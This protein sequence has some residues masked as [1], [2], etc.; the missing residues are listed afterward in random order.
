MSEDQFGIDDSKIAYH[1]DRVNQWLK[2]SGNVE[3]QLLVYPIYIEI[4]PMGGCNHRCT[5]CAVD[6]LGYIDSNILIPDILKDRLDE[7]GEKGVKSIMYAGEGEPLMSKNLA[8]IIRHT[9]EEAGI[10]VA[11]T[12]NA[13]PLTEKFA[14]A[15]LPYTTWI[16]ASIN[17]GT[18]EDYAKIHRA[19]E[20][21]FERAWKNMK[22]AAEIRDEL[23]LDHD[24]HTLGAQMVLLP[25]NAEHAVDFAQRAKDSGLDYAVIKPYSQH[26]SSNTRIYE[27]L[28]YDKFLSMEDELEAMNTDDF[29]VVFREKAMKGLD[30]SHAE[31][32]TVCPSTPFMWAYI[33]ATGD[34][35]GCSAYLQDDRFL[36]GN[37]HDQTFVEIWEGERRRKAIDFVQNELD[38]T[39]CRTN[40]RMRQVNLFLE[41][42][43]GSD[44]LEKAGVSKL[45]S[46]QIH[47]NF[48]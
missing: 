2:A 32:Y 19:P 3:K 41:G 33:M 36:Y 16:K 28:R 23:H 27:G 48:I 30:T 22:K 9:K 43:K 39:G 40:C 42:V 35:Y 29:Q 4:S 1:P 24:E 45:D 38:I 26:K 20:N 6:Y 17:A 47:K 21:H 5:F 31:N 13:T 15:A 46:N 34:V 37:I 18:A 8:D 7:M 10:D 12:T 25:E 14:N 44:S 11:I